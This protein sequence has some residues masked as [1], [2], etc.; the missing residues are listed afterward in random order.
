[1]K[2][3]KGTFDL[4]GELNDYFSDI[5][6]KIEEK[7]SVRIVQ[8]IINFNNEE[9]KFKFDDLLAN[10][11]QD[12]ATLELILKKNITFNIFG[13]TVKEFFN[14]TMKIV[15]I[16]EKFK[17]MQGAANSTIPLE[18]FDFEYQGNILEEEKTL[19]DYVTPSE[20]EFT[21]KLKGENTLLVKLVSEVK[22]YQVCL[23]KTQSI[24]DLKKILNTSFRLEESKVQIFYNGPEIIDDVTFDTFNIQGDRIEMNFVAN[25][26]YTLEVKTL[27][28]K[29]IEISIDITSTVEALKVAVQKVEG[30]PVDQQRMIYC[31]KQLEDGR[32]LIDYGIVDKSCLHLVLR[33]RGGGGGPGFPFADITQ[34][35]LAKNLQWSSYAPDWRY[36]T[37]DGLCVEGRCMNYQCVAWPNYVIV[38]KGL[39]TFDLIMDEHTN[40]CPMCLQYV[41]AEKCAFNNCSYGYT[42]LMAQGDGEPPKKVTTQKEVDVGDNYK[43]FDPRDVGTANWLTLKIVTKRLE[44]PVPVEHED[45]EEDWEDLFG[46][47]KEETGEEKEKKEEVE[48]SVKCGICLKNIEG[49]KTVLDCA[50]LYHPECIEKISGLNV[51]CAFCH[52]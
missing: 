43:L 37:G 4:Y 48:E 36:V 10:G 22:K 15:E 49:E 5:Q 41:K 28:G 11:I 39:G 20:A 8:Q 44:K 40:K 9:V 25:T 32:P 24:K 27:T 29:T 19:N 21:I 18:M 35:H 38:N 7:I 42:G 31:G 33:L 6:R 1:V 16:R 17:A 14:P 45:C 2:W 13:E 52:F 46:Y 34:N 50:H 30:I 23:L 51:K 12:E 47:E 3:E 26:I